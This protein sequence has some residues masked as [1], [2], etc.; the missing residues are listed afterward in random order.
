VAFDSAEERMNMRPVPPAADA[1]QSQAMLVSVV[2]E[3]DEASVTRTMTLDGRSVYFRV[4]GPRLPPKLELYDFAVMASVF[5]AMRRNRPLH[6]LG[7]VSAALLRNLEEFQEAWAIWM[8]GLYHVVP[9]TAEREVETAPV[10]PGRKGVFAFSGGLDSTF[11]LL[12]H[13]RRKAGR[14]TV[15]PALAVLVQGFDLPLGNAQAL[16]TARR[17]AEP[18]LDALGVP[19]SLVETNWKRDLCYHWQMEH[20]AGLAACLNQFHGLADVAVVGGDEGYDYVNLPWGSNQITNGM[21]SGGAM[22]LWTEGNGFPRSERLAFVAQNSDLASRIRVCW[23]NGD[24]GR[25]CGTCEKCIRT[26]LNFRAVGLEPEGFDRKAG[27]FRIAMVPTPSLDENYALIETQKAAGRRG[28]RGL[29]R[30]AVSIAIARNFALTPVIVAKSR[31]KAAI[32]KR[33]WLYGAFKGRR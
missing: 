4:T 1:A 8:P 9:V 6:V 18:V 7:P 11:A 30:L 12:R 24:T 15:E 25:N 27:F 33:E 2:E 16:Q 19:L 31:L 26:Q 28:I 21:L 10:G 13:A 23:E 14:R 3:R 20:L 17:S 32:K 22:S 5:T 29:W